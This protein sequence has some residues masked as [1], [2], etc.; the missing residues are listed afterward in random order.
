MDSSVGR[1]EG[2]PGEEPRQVLGRLAQGLPRAGTREGRGP[3]TGQETV[4]FALPAG[5]ALPSPAGRGGG[6]APAQGGSKSSQVHSAHPTP[7]TNQDTPRLVTRPRSTCGL[8]APPQATPTAGY[9][10]SLQPPALPIAL[11]RV[12]ANPLT[13]FPLE[14]RPSPPTCGQPPFFNVPAYAT[15]STRQGPA[16][17]HPPIYGSGPPQGLPLPRPGTAPGHAPSQ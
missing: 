14:A 11:G 8:P 9:P 5:Q 1:K 16:F 12:Q 4:G 13:S 3:E 10:P 2:E 7:K 17:P 15:P 6:R